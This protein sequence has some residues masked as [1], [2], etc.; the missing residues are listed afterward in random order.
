LASADL[1]MSQPVLSN[2]ALPIG[3]NCTEQL[4]GSADHGHRRARLG[5]GQRR[6]GRLGQRAKSG[7]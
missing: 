6:V 2:V 1:A 5:M 7:K 3:S 4:A